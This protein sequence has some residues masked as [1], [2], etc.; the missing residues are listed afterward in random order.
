MGFAL[1]TGAQVPKSSRHPQFGQ[2]LGTAW[3]V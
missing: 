3:K 1:S 2:Q